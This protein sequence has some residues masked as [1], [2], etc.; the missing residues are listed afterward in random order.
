VGSVLK[1]AGLENSK[2]ILSAAYLKDPTDPTWKDDP[3]VKEWEAFMVKY[4][5]EGDR[6]ST[7]TVFGYLLGQTMIHVLKQCGNDL[8]RENV[9]RQAANLKGL[10]LDML[11]P[12]IKINTSSNDYYP[13]KQM[14]MSRFN[15]ENV[16]LF[17][18]VLSSGI[19]GE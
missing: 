18:P 10:E 1:P 4:Y 3:A 14:Q 13:V 11:L 17:G 7:F 12:G 16:E 5:P 9:M 19:A 15:G 8:T 2:G 6:T